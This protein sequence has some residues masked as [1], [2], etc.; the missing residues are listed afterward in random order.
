MLQAAILQ[1]GRFLLITHI[2]PCAGMNTVGK[3]H[4][5]FHL[6]CLFLVL[7]AWFCLAAR[8]TMADESDGGLSNLQAT[9]ASLSSANFAPFYI[10]GRA[11]SGNTILPGVVVIACTADGQMFSTA[12]DDQGRYSL[13]VPA[14][15]I[16]LVHVE[17]FGFTAIDRILP[18]NRQKTEADFSLELSGVPSTESQSVAGATDSHPGLKEGPTEHSRQSTSSSSSLLSA[19]LP[20][21]FS[22]VTGKLAQPVGELDTA[23]QSASLRQWPIHFNASYLGRNSA[24]DAT[25]YAL[26]GITAAKPEYAQNTFSAGFGGTLPWGK[27]KAIT[28]L[29]GSYNASRNG[30]PYSGFATVP[31]AALRAGD[32]SGLTTASGAATGRGVTIFDPATGQPFVDNRIRPERISPVALALLQYMPLPTRPGLSQNFRFVTAN[33]SRIDGFGLSLTRSS[34]VHANTNPSV[35]SNLNVSLGYHRSTADLPNVFPFLGGD[36]VSRAWNTGVGYTLTKSFFINNLNVSFNLMNSQTLNHFHQDVAAAVGIRGVSRDRFDWG[37][38][39]ISFAQFTGL[40]DISSALRADRNFS[41]TD[42]VSWT[43]GKHNLKWGGELRLLAFDLRS[44]RDAE[45]SFAFTGFATVGE[46]NGARLPETGFDFA[47]FL[48]GLPQ[49][50]HVQYSTGAFSFRGNTWNLYFLDDWRIRKNLSL[51]LGLR[52]EFVSPFYEAHNRLVTLDAPPDFSGVAIVRAGSIGPFSGHFPSTIVESDRNDFAPR[53]GVAWRPAGHLIVRAGYSID[54]DTGQYNSLATELA[55]QPPFAVGQTAIASRGQ[56]LTLTNGFPT[57]QAGAVA[58]NFAVARHLPLSYAQI[59]VVQVQNELPCGF[60][61]MTSYMG[62]SGTDLQMLRAPNRS[63]TGLL[64]PKVAPFL[65]QANEGSSV[66]H[67]GSVALEKRLASG[68]SFNASYVFSR[69]IDNTPALGDETQVA[70]DDRALERDRSLSAFDQRHRAS[71]S[72]AYEPPFG[73]GRRW[74]NTSGIGNQLLGGWFLTGVINYASGFPFTPHVLGAF[75]DVETGGFGALRPD[76]TGEPVHLSQTTTDRFFNTGAFIAPP[77]G[78]YGDAGRNIITGPSIFTFAAGLAKLFTISDRHS[79]R[80]RVEATNLL[81]TPQ[82]TQIDTNLNSFSYGQITGV[83]AMRSI[84]F[85]VQ[86]SF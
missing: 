1:N 10:S 37:L 9:E 58:N 82:F 74:L 86:Y 42:S 46:M 17:L 2:R 61:L 48:L 68:L 60:T 81:N 83:G 57:L 75:G 33:Q 70:Q 41:F 47:D 21:D 24:L 27:K 51:N 4:R 14:P 52:Y 26:Q 29:F 30:N 3:E 63:A 56:W 73:H 72:Y 35:R 38:P 43:H 22:F 67:A 5:C 15:A 78:E 18:V 7:L 55:L 54:Y 50:T 28:S 20:M 62:T 77:V 76:L 44:S 23:G 66:L 31:T 6:S 12:S 65:W 25:P 11:F 45:G 19:Y 71:M 59:W 40:Q 84:Q 80:F 13:A 85:G 16:Y 36:I 69:S 32:F 64:L 49:K 53:F 34:S 39:S 8:R 79:L